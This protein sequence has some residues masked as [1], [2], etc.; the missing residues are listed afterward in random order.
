MRHDMNKN[1]WW[2]ALLVLIP[3]VSARA[4]TAP[5]EQPRPI[6]RVYVPRDEFASLLAK[7]DRPGRLVPVKELKSLLD[8]DYR[9]RVERE[10]G[11]KAA[12]DR[13]QA[14]FPRDLVVDQAEIGAVV[15]PDR[16][17]ARLEVAL[18][19]TL[20]NVKDATLAL[21]AKGL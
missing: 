19:L 14:R 2:I 9:R 1:P 13:E 4:E 5:L 18:A 12:S 16:T 10:A 21:P 15:S 20:H 8:A 3:L 6:L 11:A 7:R 17:F